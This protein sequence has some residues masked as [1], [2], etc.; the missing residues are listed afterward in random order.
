MPQHAL[1][2]LTCINVMIPG[3]SNIIVDGV[4]LVASSSARIIR[5]LSPRA[6]ME[7]SLL[8]RG[9]GLGRMLIVIHL[10]SP[11]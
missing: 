7:S 2:S 8:D 11:D 4:A 6:T 1:I 9:T 5:N 3:I 10:W